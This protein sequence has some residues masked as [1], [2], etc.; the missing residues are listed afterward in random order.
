MRWYEFKVANSAMAAGETKAIIH[1]FR[2]EMHQAGTE[3][4]R[5]MGIWSPGATGEDHVMFYVSMLAKEHGERFLR[6]HNA[7]RC[8]E[9]EFSGLL[10]VVGSTWLN[11]FLR[12]RG[13]LER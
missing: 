2:N 5:Y 6:S 12:S 8:Q 10:F 9:P 4:A 13:G 1:S 7:Q 3:A 11:G